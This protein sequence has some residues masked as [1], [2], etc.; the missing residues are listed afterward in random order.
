LIPQADKVMNELLEGN[1]RFH[2]GRP[3]SNV[4]S[5][6]EIA[7][8]A[9][10]Q[11]PIAAVIA[12]SDSRVTPEVV[13]DQPLGAL[14]ASRVPGNVASDSAKWMLE[15][16]VGEFHVPL[17]MVMGHTGC[18]A[19]GQLLDGDKGGAGGLHRFSVLSAVYRARQKRTDDLYRTS[20]EE[21]VLQTVEHLARDLFTLRRALV[22]KTTS[23]VG[24]VYHMETGQVEILPT[25]IE[26][27]GV[28]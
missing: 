9:V 11:K 3:R 22:E 28:Y 26:L 17:V 5:P 14:F 6:A 10:Q 20:I 15:L 25:K 21:N 4:Y 16:A 12:C 18:L 23:I 24:A 2:S 7:A 13:F 1:R 19:V 8:I 27:Y